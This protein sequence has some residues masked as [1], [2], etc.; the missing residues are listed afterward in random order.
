MFKHGA[1]D[2]VDAAMLRATQHMSRYLAQ[3]DLAAMTPN[4]RIVAGVRA[5]VEYT[6]QWKRTWPQ[7]MAVGA[8]PQNAVRT[9]EHLGVVVD[10]IWFYA[11]DRSTDMQW[12]SRR[13]LLLGVYVATGTARSPHAVS[14]AKTTSLTHARPDVCL[15]QSW[16]C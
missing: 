14:A 2:L 9:A 3:L 4:E 5:R 6:A 10:E 16:L 11:G 13:G 12:Y 1:A 8:L 7:A 15:H